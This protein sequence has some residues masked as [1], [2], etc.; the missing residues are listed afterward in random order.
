MNSR[1]IRTAWACLTLLTGFC[2][3][4]IANIFMKKKYRLRV[5]GDRLQ[6]ETL[7]TLTPDQTRI[8]TCYQSAFNHLRRTIPWHLNCLRISR[9]AQHLL[10]W[11]SVPSTLYVGIDTRSNDPTGHAWLR[12]GDI[13]ITADGSQ[14]FKICTTF[15]VLI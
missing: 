7:K 14:Q 8:A 5:P 11:H 15:A 2:V 4:S 10:T 6:T 1:R 9:A 3:L 13:T 12:A